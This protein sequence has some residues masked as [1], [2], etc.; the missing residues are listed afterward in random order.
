MAVVFGG[1]DKETVLDY[2]F[3]LNHNL[4]NFVRNVD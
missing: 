3:Y 4:R 2:T 1:S